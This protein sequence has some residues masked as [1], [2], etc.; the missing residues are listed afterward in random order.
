MNLFVQIGNTQI[1][2]SIRHSEKA[3]KKRLVVKPNNVELVVPVGSSDEANTAFILSKKKWLYDALQELEQKQRMQLTQHY[4][5]GAK[6]QYRG[7][8]L[9]IR[10]I[11][12]DVGE[13]S[14]SYSSKF[15]VSVPQSLNETE[16]LLA[17]KNAFDVYLKNR[18]KQLSKQWVKKYERLLTVT[19]KNVVMYESK[20]N[21][22]TCGKDDIIRINWKLIQAPTVAMKYVVAHEVT[23]LVHRNHSEEFWLELG[24]AM[25]NWRE[26]KAALEQWETEHRAV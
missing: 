23:H 19:S 4:G 10:L 17:V 6:L 24:K 12:E 3:K 5:S 26:G 21:W 9:M 15:E 7:R 25:P 18:A 13:V 20:H 1:P 2:Y 16:R 11:K 22:G 8:W 14:I